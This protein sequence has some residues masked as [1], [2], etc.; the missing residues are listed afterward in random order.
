MEWNNTYAVFSWKIPGMGDNHPVIEYCGVGIWGTREEESQTRRCC[1][2][3]RTEL[4]GLR[5]SVI[6][7]NRGFR[8]RP[9]GYLANCPGMGLRIR[10]NAKKY[11]K[12]IVNSTN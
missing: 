4:S 10:Q 2:Y 12:F 6:C 11:C 7:R 3:F 5:L 8:Q 1:T 9:G